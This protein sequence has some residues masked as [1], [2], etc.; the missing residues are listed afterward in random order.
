M[1]AKPQDREERA[2]RTKVTMIEYTS[3]QKVKEANLTS[4]SALKEALLDSPFKSSEA[5][6]F[7]LFLVEDLSQQVIEVLGSRFDVDPLFFREQIADYT[8]FYTRDPWAMA[9]P[10]MAGMKHRDWFR[11][12][13]VR[14]RYLHNKESYERARHESNDF[15]IFRRLDDDDSHWLYLDA[16]GSIIA[17]IR[18]RT[19]I[20]MGKDPRN[21][22]ENVG[23]V[24]LDPTISEGSPL[25]YGPTNWRIPP[26]LNHAEPTR[27][28]MP[29]SLFN[30]V[31]QAT[32]SYPWFSCISQKNT[33]DGQI[34]VSPTLY[35]V[36]AEWLV[37]CEYIKARV[38]QIDW[39][40]EKPQLFR[41]KGDVIESSLRRLHIC[42][43]S[44]W[45][46]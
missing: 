24:L 40:L 8:W 35:T 15:N 25:W 29:D 1:R 2:A 4:G 30:L 12:R 13:H 5:P 20:W 45:S 44:L 21:E 9:P 23:I 32:S 6:T 28:G 19:T 22:Q 37:L 26:S 42:M 10:L 14:F 7:R 34:F 39:E 18:T 17:M 3:N 46:I 36:C 31:T 16:P 11:M 27:A 33:T 43:R 41:S 38:A